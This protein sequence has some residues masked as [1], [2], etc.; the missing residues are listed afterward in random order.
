MKERV[1]VLLSGGTVITGFTFLLA[2]SRTT[3]VE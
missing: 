1:D 3:V 2:R